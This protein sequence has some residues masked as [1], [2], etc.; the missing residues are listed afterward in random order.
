[1]DKLITDFES[2]YPRTTEMAVRVKEMEMPV[3]I[4]LWISIN[5]S[6]L[7]TKLKRGDYSAYQKSKTPM[8]DEVIDI[9]GKTYLQNIE[10]VAH[11]VFL[12][13]GEYSQMKTMKSLSPDNFFLKLINQEC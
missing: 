9:F 6:V 12:L 13:T 2:N 5:V 10:K 8:K 1:M 3:E 4:N 7:M 11:Q